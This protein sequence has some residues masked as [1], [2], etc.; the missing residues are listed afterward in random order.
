M[1]FQL[2]LLGW[3]L[4]RRDMH[5]S[6]LLHRHMSPITPPASCRTGAA[7]VCDAAA[8]SPARSNPHTSRT[9][10]EKRGE[11]RSYVGTRA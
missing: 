9:H 4:L 10:G 3:M 7:A 5:V 2:W 1:Q 8:R 6:G 11:I